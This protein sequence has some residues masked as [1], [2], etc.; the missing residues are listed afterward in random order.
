M[1]AITPPAPAV[2]AA[3]AVQTSTEPTTI[4]PANNNHAKKRPRGALN[5]MARTITKGPRLL[6]RRI[7]HF[8]KDDLYLDVHFQKAP[9]K[10]VTKELAVLEVLSVYHRWLRGVQALLSIAV[11]ILSLLSVTHSAVVVN[12][13]IFVVSQAACLVI[14]KTYHVKAQFSGVTNVLF[15][16]R[17][18]FTSPYFPNMVAELILW[19]IQTPPWMWWGQSFFNLLDYFIFLR[20]YSIVIYL[21]NAAYVY[22][23][24]CRAM[25]AISDL[26]LSTSFMIRTGLLYNKVRIGTIVVLCTWLSIGFMYAR[27]ESV[28]FGDAMWFSFQSLATLGYGDITPSNLSGR[29][30]TLIAWLASYFLMAYLIIIMYSLLRA[31]EQSQNM[32][33]LMECHDLSHS[34]RNRSARVIQIAWKLHRVRKASPDPAPWKEKARTLILSWML[35]HM[36]AALRRTRQRLSDAQRSLQEATVHPLTGLSAFQYSAFLH[37]TH[38][39]ARHLQRVKDVDR[40]YMALRERDV[41]ASSLSRRDIESILILPGDSLEA[42]TTTTPFGILGGGVGVGAGAESAAVVA[43]VAQW[44]DRVS[45]LEQ[46]CARLSEVLDRMSAIAETHPPSMAVSQI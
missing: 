3:S 40:V 16:G 26:P 24:F 9:P 4:I 23:T 22:R 45:Q 38:K 15:E 43:E 14:C 19:N 8:L 34:L 42:D 27:A 13:T 2:P 25:S 28:S 18:I 32:Q 44:K 46:K 37:T 11:F 10:V 39:S 35:T 5:K 20:M 36:I 29:A 21:N 41:P 33:T 30:V 12:C 6:G 31:S 1:S 7:K 17:N